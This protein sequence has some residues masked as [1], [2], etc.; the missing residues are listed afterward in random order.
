[1][2]AVA[3][4]F[5]DQNALATAQVENTRALQMKIGLAHDI[6]ADADVLFDVADRGYGVAGPQPAQQQ[7]QF[8]L[9]LDLGKSRKALCLS[10]TKSISVPGGSPERARGAGR[11]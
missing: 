2:M 11:R 3:Q 7:S 9:F 1:M 10:S 8:D 5:L 6:A 4:V